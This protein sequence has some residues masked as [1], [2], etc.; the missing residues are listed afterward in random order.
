MIPPQQI[1][2]GHG[3]RIATGHAGDAWP[4][5]GRDD[6]LAALTNALTGPTPCSVVLV[7][8]AGVGKT[9]LAREA[10]RRAAANGRETR[11]VTATRS[12]GRTPFGALTALLPV[13]NPGDGGL[14]DSL[15]GMLR[16]TARSLQDL[17]GDQAL[18]LFVDDAQLLDDASAG[19]IQQLVSTGAVLV[20]ATVRSG[21]TTPDGVTA[22]WKDDFAIRI[23][24]AD[25]GDHA[26]DDLLT[27]ALGGQVDRAAVADLTARCQGNVLFLRELVHGALVDGTLADEGGVWRLTGPLAPSDRIVELVDA[28]LAGLSPEARAL[29]ELTAYGEP[30]G[31]AEL[32]TLADE[33]LATELQRQGLLVCSRDG[34]RLQLR[35]AHPLYADVLR[36][37]TSVVR[38]GAMARSLADLVEQAGARRRDDLLRVGIWRLDGG[39]GDPGVLLGAAR[40][41]RWHYDFGLAERLARA[42]VESGAGF[43]GR[44][45][46]AQTAALQGRAEDAERQLAGL[47]PEV[48]DD[49]QRARVAIARIDGL[50]LSLGR[51]REGLRVADEAE[52]AISDPDLRKE[53]SSHRAGLVLGSE[54]P[55]ATVRV[56]ESML[57]TAQGRSLVWCGVI[58]GFGLGRLGRLQEALELADRAYAAGMAMAEPDDWYPWFNRHAR[59]EILVQAGRFAEAERLAREQHELGL[60]EGS[61]EARA[62]FLW[63]L[64]RN[65]RE[66]GNVRA[67]ER[68]AREAATLLDRLGRVGVRHTLLSLLA[69]AQALSGD[70]VGARRSLSAIKALRIEQPRWSW[71]DYLAAEAW[72]A[73]AEGRVAQGRE[74][75]AEAARVGERIGDRTGAAAALHDIARLGAPRLVVDHLS[76]L[77]SD[78]EGD[79]VAT[80]AAHVRA[81]ASDDPRALDESAETFEALDAE[82]LAAEAAADA[83]VAWRRAG[84]V[85]RADRGLHRAALLARRCEGAVTPALSPLEVRVQLTDAER[86]TARLAAAGRSNAEIAADLQ[87]SIRTVENRL[88][89]VYHKLGVRRRTELVD[90]VR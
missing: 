26:I 77:A 85:R 23:S 63:N 88:Q 59:C 54:G 37:Q 76:V 57:P 41:A 44:L 48:V 34:R 19:L 40:A 36:A 12:V 50:W 6:E 81:L 66:R 84:D 68:D 55:A 7:G 62:W 15:E 80:R 83:A 28:R 47:A 29:L 82:L 90:L 20:V 49:D 9:R 69:Q 58:G 53:V 42:A 31:S 75:L 51:M 30:L 65:T 10:M 70:A 27:A 35:L 1:L 16:R 11:W 60:D 67:A 45:L 3:P 56:L 21:G 13:A 4:L 39:G 18:L 73:V 86:E 64:S 87:L 8:A 61:S 71:T 43:E 5:T 74:T 79:L 2:P 33:N 38:I 46:A 78:L 17:G 32:A 24:L 72:T 52:A 25:L 22:L 89:R 14:P